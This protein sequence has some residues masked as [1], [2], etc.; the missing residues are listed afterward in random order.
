MELKLGVKTVTC[1]KIVY[2]YEMNY[3]RKNLLLFQFDNNL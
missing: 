3:V 2:L 1:N